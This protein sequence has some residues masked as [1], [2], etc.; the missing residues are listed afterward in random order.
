M[1]LQCDCYHCN[2]KIPYDEA[3]V[4]CP[5]CASKLAELTATTN[6]SSVPCGDCGKLLLSNME[7]DNPECVRV[8]MR[9]GT[10]WPNRWA[11]CPW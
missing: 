4:I 3:S 10:R 6:R 9:H 2:G 1:D 5:T 11:K 8:I 7:C